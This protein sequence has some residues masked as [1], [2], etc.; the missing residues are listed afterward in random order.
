[1][2]EQEWHK[3]VR[4]ELYEKHKK[5]GLRVET[6]HSV[7][8]NLELFRG[9]PRRANCLSDADLIVF[10]SNGNVAQIIEIES[11]PNPKKVSGVVVA[12]NLCSLCKIGNETHPLSNV[13]LEIVYRKPKAKSKKADKLEVMYEPLREMVKNGTWGCLSDFKWDVHE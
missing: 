11:E 7:N 12:T 1:M 5:M 3:R 9:S 6:S 8:P 2:K 13:F 4:E 10:D